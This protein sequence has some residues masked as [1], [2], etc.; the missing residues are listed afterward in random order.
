MLAS[1]A[2]V[3]GWLFRFTSCIPTLFLFLTLTVS[4]IASAQQNASAQE[5]VSES[6]GRLPLAFEA[7]E[8]QASSDVRYLARGAD[9]MLLIGETDAMLARRRTHPCKAQFRDVKAMKTHC[10]EGDD[11]FHMQLLGTQRQG[12]A[13]RAVRGEEMLPGK[14]NTL[15][16]NDPKHW[17]AGASTYRRVRIAEAYP[18][19]DLVYYG[20]QERLEYDFD[21]A[22]GADPKAIRFRFTGGRLRLNHEG[23]LVA[24]VRGEDVIFRR[25][26]IYQRV[27][28]IKRKIAGG[29]VLEGGSTLRFRVGRYDRRQPLIIDPVL[30]YSTY[31]N[32]TYALGGI[33]VN[34]AGEAYITGVA[35]AISPTPGAYQQTD[36]N[37]TGFGGNAY[38]MKLNA[39]GTNVVYATYL[40][41]SGGFQILPPPYAAGDAGTAIAVDTSGDAYLTG[42]TY[43]QDF[44]TMNP[45]QAQNNGVADG[46]GNAFVTE[47]NPT[48]TALVYSTF[49]G[50]TGLGGTGAQGLSVIGTG[51]AVDSTGAA[52]VAGNTNS[53]DFPTT[54]GAL[55]SGGPIFLAK[56]VPGGTSLAYSTTLG[57]GYVTATGMAIDGSGAAYVTGYAFSQNGG[58]IAATPGAYQQ[59]NHSAYQTN[60]F[61]AKLNPTGTALGYA[62]YLGGSGRNYTNSSG[63]ISNVADQ[64]NAIAVD[65]SG[66]AYITGSAGSEDFPITSGAMQTNNVSPPGLSNAFVTKLNPAG[67]ALVYSTYLGGTG[68][69]GAP[70]VTISPQGY[71][72]QG[73]AIVVDTAGDAYVAG[74]TGS[75]DFPVTTN[76]YQ[77]TNG[78]LANKNTNAFVSKLNP[79]GSGL[80][81][82]TYLGGSGSTMDYSQGDSASAI[83]VDGSGH[84]YIGGSV[85]SSNFPTTPGAFETTGG[86]GFVS[87]FDLGTESEYALSVFPATLDLLASQTGTASG[88]MP[89]TIT[90]IGSAGVAISGISIAGT[91]AAEFTQTNTCGATLATND[92]CTVSVIFTPTTTGQQTATL[93]IADNVPG[94][95]QAVSLVGNEPVYPPTP[96]FS[97]AQLAF[98]SQ[99]GGTS[100]TQTATL[101][102]QGKGPFTL[103]SLTVSD[104]WWS[105]TNTCGTTLAAGASCTFTVT[106]RPTGNTGARTAQILIQDY[107][108]NTQATLVLSG[109]Q[110][111]VGFYLVGQSLSFSGQAVGTT[112]GYQM[113]TFINYTGSAVTIT[114]INVT[115]D[116]A[117]TTTCNG[118]VPVA[119]GQPCDLLV[120]FTPTAA[121]TRTGTVTI[122]DTAPDSP[123]TVALT[124]TG[125]APAVTL[126]A[127]TLSFA[128]QVVGSTSATQTVMLTNTGNAALTIASITTTGDF[129][130]TNNCGSSQPAGGGICYIS[131]TFTPTA[132]G[133][134]TGTLLITDNASGS[135]QTVTLTGTG[136]PPVALSATTLSFAQQAVGLTSAAQTVML[137]NAGQTA[138]K[139]ASIAASGDF[140]ETNTC[141]SSLAAG[142]MCNIA[143]TFTPTA[144]GT[145]TG[146]LTITDNAMGS[147]QTVALTGVGIAPAVTLSATTLSFAQ[148]ALG[149]TS[150]AQTVTLTN[151][152]QAALAIAAFS[153]SGDFA[154]TN[155]CGSS[156]VAGA[157]CNIAVTFTPTATGTR[158]GILTITDNATG[159]PQVVALSGSG[160]TPVPVATLTPA[161][162][163]FSPQTVGSTSAAQTV[164]LTNSGQAA[165]TIASISAS[166]DFAETNTCGTSLAV[167]ANCSIAVTFTP[168]DSGSRSGM[169]TVTDNATGSPQTVALSG[170]GTSVGLA[171]GSSN[172][173][174]SMAGGSA[175]DAIT[176]SSLQGFSGMVALSCTVQAVGNEAVHDMPTCTLNPT[177]V[178]VANSSP[179]SATLTV[180][181][182]AATSSAR[183]ALAFLGGGVLLTILLFGG[184]SGWRRRLHGGAWLILLLGLGMLGVSTGCGG[185]PSTP[186]DPGTTAGSYQVTVT[187]TET[188]DAKVTA[189]ATISLTL[190]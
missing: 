112:S 118:V 30:S 72:D 66:N 187:A 159:S 186:S 160:I 13:D 158:N 189:T 168:T 31:I 37:N 171:A 177:Q 139:L 85:D 120:S 50:G 65:G 181:T 133:T 183:P 111:A 115:G 69:A 16:G 21:V 157:T 39:S 166:G 153:A 12:G 152:G 61:V 77:S 41:G 42:F 17:H 89:V 63:A 34:A 156:L 176:V 132:T 151:S 35:T 58:G 33:A 23:D 5:R 38:V 146:T 125:V 119:S 121:G 73:N 87:E 123:Q 53:G 130:Q 161:T 142:T 114:S 10:R 155:T 185:H 178:Q 6:Y 136:T 57:N 100:T 154:Q 179:V 170:T 143:V 101:T 134:R 83:T 36:K 64:G 109:T 140:A 107:V 76:A 47:L 147:P 14:V 20:D 60:A 172:L 79:A 127:S 48:G 3:S 44:P 145:R 173:T 43:S 163:T 18:G 19:I 86:G 117:A 1:L 26:E 29:F 97:P 106:F 15:L 162:L 88:A 99:A 188:S 102:N 67:T 138:L 49:L 2:L 82:S 103:S 98:G 59:T 190:Q 8:G 116:F 62:T 24:R 80:L 93:S 11:L 110:L 55:Q 149:S 169:I 4:E 28:G 71:G 175:T 52:Y 92:S 144:A 164:T 74:W 124:G 122:T 25:P 135:P 40:G 84:V 70:P 174:I 105:Q 113:T 150:A 94:S 7:N 56:F 104:A 45:V 68:S 182:D 141:G 27:G 137:T 165:L 129:A 96:V 81:Y 9:Y 78:A 128:Q 51:I 91:N 95:P 180:S 22:P 54:P 32:G 108:S 46:N 90:N 131:V 167:G 75:A 148:Q 184:M 126:S